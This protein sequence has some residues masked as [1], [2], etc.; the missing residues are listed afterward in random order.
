MQEQN[1]KTSMLPMV[2]SKNIMIA[3]VLLG[4]MTAGLYLLWRSE[5]FNKTKEIDEEEI[6]EGE[7]CI[8]D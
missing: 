4:G 2:S 3:G 1:R 8:C 5:Y 7:K 6:N